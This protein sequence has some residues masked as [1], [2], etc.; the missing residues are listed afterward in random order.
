MFRMILLAWLA[1]LPSLAPAYVG[2]GVSVGVIGMILGVLASIVLAVLGIFWYPIKRMLGRGKKDK[3][4]V[5]V[6]D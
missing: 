6:V 2:P 5:E 4:S 3:T 1:V